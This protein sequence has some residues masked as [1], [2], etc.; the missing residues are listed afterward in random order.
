MQKTLTS[1][2]ESRGPRQTKYSLFPIFATHIILGLWAIQTVVF[3]ALQLSFGSDIMIILMGAISLICCLYPL[4]HKGWTDLPA[5][6]AFTLLSKYS[7][8]PFWIKTIYGQRIDVGLEA[9]FNTFLIMTIGSIIT[10]MALFIVRLIP[11]KKRLLKSLI[12]ARQALFMG[13]IASTLGLIFLFLHVLY[14]P[15]PLSNGRVI[16]GFG[17]FGSFTGLLYLGIICIVS[18]NLQK[19][20]SLLRN[21]FLLLILIGAL[22]LSTFDNGKT[23]FSFAILAYFLTILY[24]NFRVKL[25]YVVYFIAIS[26]FY[27]LVFAP[28]IHLTRTTS[29][30]TA[31]FYEKT[32]MVSQ[33]LSGNS[34]QT[35]L[36]ESGRGFRTKYYPQANSFLIDRL[37]MIQDLDL[38]AARM[39]P[40]RT[41]GWQPIQM[42]FESIIPSILLPGKASIVDIDLIAFKIGLTGNL[43]VTRHTLGVFASTY[44][45][46]MW[47]EWMPIT[48]LILLI[49]FLMLKFIVSSDMKNNIFAIYLLTKYCFSFS[50]VSVQELLGNMLRTIPI[51]I[52]SFI[53]ITFIS[54]FVSSLIK[55]R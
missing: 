9:P 17:G 14:R 39:T 13:Y 46:F 30:K 20:S 2:P 7:L 41:I 36:F 37:E 54:R 27:V 10:C 35:L 55:R 28:V 15:V 24:F 53:L 48:L 50:E 51:D 25:H 32:Q 3:I 43:R 38:V 45:M 26:M 16:P 19:G 21:I 34:T 12:P 4:M 22:I 5:M 23:N 47:P 42:A 18:V 1:H 29:F 6:F 44:A 33:L 52:I 11:A 49:Y 8:L 31:D 40:S